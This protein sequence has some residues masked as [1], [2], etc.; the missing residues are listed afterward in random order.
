M[1]I[2]FK[3][4]KLPKGIF[5]IFSQCAKPAFEFEHL[6]L[7]QRLSLNKRLS[8][9][10]RLDEPFSSFPTFLHQNE[11]K[12]SKQGE[13]SKFPVRNIQLM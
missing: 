13:N 7:N 5:L 6:S 9:N 11:S 10:Q 1:F 3:F 2:I 8:V 12:T 4:V